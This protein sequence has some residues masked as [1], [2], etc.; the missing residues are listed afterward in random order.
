MVRH[1]IMQ[2]SATFAV[3][4]AS[5]DTEAL[6]S[7]ITQ[8]YTRHELPKEL[9]VQD[10]CESTL[11]Q[12][13]LTDL[14]KGQ[15][16]I[17]IPKIGIKKQL[18]DMSFEN[19]NNYLLSNLEKLKHKEDRTIHACE[20][21]QQILALKR[22]PKR[23]E[24]Y[25]ISN[26]S[27]V[28]KV[29]SMVVFDNGEPDKKSYRRFK[30]K[31]VEGA[32]DFASLQE[33]LKRR[34]SKLGTIEESKFPKPD[35]I[36]IDGGKG[37]LSSVQEIFKAMQIDDIEL[38]SL[39]KREEEIFTIYSKESIQLSKRD[40]CLQMLQ[41]I[42]DE[43]HRFAITF[44]R[45]IHNKKSLKSILEEVHGLGKVKIEQLLQ[46]FGNIDKILKATPEE[47]AS[48]EGI[49]QHLAIIIKKHLEEKL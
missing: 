42:R 34:L 18:L 5:D 41:H 37:Q 29:G 43:A 27:G 49:G 22:Y 25:D 28:D 15:R 8:Y 47:L 38:I 21:L 14:G 9:I 24:C 39:A 19:A 31:T 13:Y 20:R 40:Y 17:T 32:N 44:F 26:I 23:M 35:L 1:G 36:I 6:T 2:G 12:K 33:V 7:F 45:N 4:N 48:V 16:I 46:T 30:I 3:E 10:F 11:L